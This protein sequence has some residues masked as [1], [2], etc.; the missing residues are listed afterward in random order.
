MELSRG[1]LAV[2][3]IWW[4]IL[5]F[6]TKLSVIEDLGVSGGILFYMGIILVMIAMCLKK[7]GEKF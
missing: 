7:K 2:F 6:I 1:R 5:P 3:G 4:M